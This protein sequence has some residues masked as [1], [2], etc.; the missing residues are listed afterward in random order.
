MLP[1][2][3]QATVALWWYQTNTQLHGVATFKKSR[4]GMSRLPEDSAKPASYQQELQTSTLFCLLQAKT[5]HH[6]LQKMTD[7]QQQRPLAAVTAYIITCNCDTL[8]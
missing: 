6:S 1:T 5:R 7:Q 2:A 8:L 4:T 3:G